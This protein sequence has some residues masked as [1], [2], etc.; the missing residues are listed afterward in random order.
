MVKVYFVNSAPLVTPHFFSPF[1][2]ETFLD[3][4]FKHLIEK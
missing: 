3:K 2:Y 1:Y 4:Y